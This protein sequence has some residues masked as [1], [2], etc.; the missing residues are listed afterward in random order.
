MSKTQLAHSIDITE[1]K[2]EYD[3]EA[4]YLVSNKQVL[5]R[6]M[7]FSVQEYKDCS[8][9]EIMGYIEGTPE[10][11]SHSVLPQN[12]KIEGMDTT[13][14]IPGEGEFSFDIRFSALT[15][16]EETIKIILNIELQKSYY[17]GYHFCSRGIFYCSRMI[18]EQAY[19]EF[20]PDNYDDI[21]K[22]YSIWLCMEPPMKY[23]NTITEYSM[24]EK[25]IYGEFIGEENY[26]LL[27][28]L[29]IRLC[30]DEKAECESQLINMLNVLLST[31]LK[32]EQKKKILEEEH[33]M[34][35]TTDVEGDV[36]K[37]CNLSD[38][39]VEQTTEKVTKEVTKEVT[40]NVTKNVTAK[41]T[42]QSVN[43][44]MGNLHW[45]LEK[46]CEALGKTVEEYQNAKRILNLK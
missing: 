14:K 33:Q 41:E 20:E 18:S 45:S 37:M 44:L 7:K 10:V 34:K 32:A 30:T 43:N 17:P 26:D 40:K 13:S 21:K 1:T 15:P 16:Q 24:N 19:T 31:K 35:M 25:D 22:V 27:S 23:A 36:D 8:I 6:I 2:S 4:K 9:E 29:V 38:L 12:E 42:V 5:A 3:T 39:I 11:S 46:A 28:V